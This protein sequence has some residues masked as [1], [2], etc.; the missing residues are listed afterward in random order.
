MG[1][2]YYH[3]RP[4]RDI[5][6][7]IKEITLLFLTIN[8]KAEGSGNQ[9]EEDT[10]MNLKLHIMKTKRESKTSPEQNAINLSS[11]VL[12]PAEKSILKKGP[13]FVPIPTNINWCNLWQDFD[14][15]VNKLNPASTA[16]S[17]ETF[18]LGNLPVKAKFPNIN[19]KREETD[20]TSLEIFTE[21]VEKDLFQQ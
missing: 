1:N 2:S 8:V 13:S 20:V 12:S 21:L 9:N 15:F 11:K 5:K 18:Q 10:V 14:S 17:L 7:N 16:L 4:Q 3:L 6:E 19:S